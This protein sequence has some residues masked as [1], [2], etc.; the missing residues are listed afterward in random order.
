MV[1]FDS[2]ITPPKSIWKLAALF[3]LQE[4][5]ENILAQDPHLWDQTRDE[6]LHA[7]SSFGDVGMVQKLLEK[8]VD[9]NV[10]GSR[11]GNAL[12]AASWHG[13]EA[14][15]RLLIDQGANVNAQGGEYGNALQAASLGERGCCPIAHRARC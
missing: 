11:Y 6:L 7:T 3:N 10:P 12:H 13:Q 1:L 8:G 15:A 2:S 9:V 14:V 5:V 4:T